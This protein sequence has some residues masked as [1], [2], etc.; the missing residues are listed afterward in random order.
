MPVLP[1]KVFITHPKFTH[2]KTIEK[3]LNSL[4]GVSWEI[5]DDDREIVI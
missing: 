2:L 4:K 3:E 5:L 1:E